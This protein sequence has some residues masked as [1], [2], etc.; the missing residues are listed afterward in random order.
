[1]GLAFALWAVALAAGCA[2][3]STESVTELPDFDRVYYV[4]FQE[5]PGLENDDI[6]VKTLRI[7]KVIG[8][9]ATGEGVD[10]AKISID[11]KYA[12][13]MRDNVVF[14]VE[15]GHLEYET[16]GGNGAPLGEGAKILGFPSRT[17]FYWFKAQNSVRSVSRAAME[18]AEELYDRSLE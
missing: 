6:F 15:D 13:L 11:A 2:P 1:M 16:V 8:Q 14:T 7:G 10:V 17:G 12:D 18:K 9:K 4:I 3:F 5:N